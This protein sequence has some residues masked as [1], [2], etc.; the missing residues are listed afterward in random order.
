M[1]RRHAFCRSALVAVIRK[2]PGW[3]DEALEEKQMPVK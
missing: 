2:Q 1:N 3:L